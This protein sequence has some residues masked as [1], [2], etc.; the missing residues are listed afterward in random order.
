MIRP[1]TFS[2]VAFDP[3]ENAFGIAVAS[4]FL[5]VGAV[6]PWVQ[7]SAGAVATQSYANTTFGPLGLARL[8]RGEPAS[9]VLQ[10]LLIEDPQASER[11][12]GIV[13][14]TGGSAT[15][16]G[17]GCNPWAGGVHGS[18]YAIQ[19]NIL[20]GPGVLAAMK[21]AFLDAAGPF[22]W[23]LYAA[24]NAGDQAG[25]DRR[26]RQSAAI[27]VVKPRGGYAGFNDRWIDYR[28]D[29]DLD[30]MARLSSLLKLHDLYFG[31]SP[32]EDK[33][34][35]HGATLVSLQ[36]ILI[37]TG[38]YTGQPHGE[39]NDATRRALEIFIGR[40]NFEDRVDFIT[41]RIDRPV[42]DYLFAHFMDQTQK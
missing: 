41:G 24:L 39:Y 13:D 40:E 33:I 18:G 11:Q 5:A 32:A 42:L 27:L 10:A 30:P 12:V 25:G 23:R 3:K 4:K 20:A 21:T 6:V 1:S 2:I 34:S 28:V 36:R 31:E 29:D 8:E 38:D 7:A 9:K 17:I 19:G 22:Y 37:K 15:Y 14:R 16:T 35:L 26:G